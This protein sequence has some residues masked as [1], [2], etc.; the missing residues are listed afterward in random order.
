[1]KKL[2]P[3]AIV[4]LLGTANKNAFAL[5]VI[6]DYSNKIFLRSSAGIL[7]NV[8]TNSGSTFIYGGANI[9]GV[10]FF[11]PKM[12]VGAAYKVETTFDA[13]PLKGFD[14]LTRYYFWGDGTV[15][16]SSDT[17]QNSLLYHSG[18]ALYAGMEFSN[19]GFIFEDDPDAFLPEDRTVSGSISAANAMLGFDIRLARNWELNTELSYTIFPFGGDDPRV[20]IKWILVSLGASFVF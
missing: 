11:T 7:N 9:G 1:M 13:V 20:K 3:L 12:A 14:I 16:K 8:G 2:I 6:N 4:V 19:R 15:V 10:Y 5:G 18:F 17:S